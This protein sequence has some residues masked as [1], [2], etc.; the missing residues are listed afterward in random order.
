MSVAE[1]AVWIIEQRRAEPLTLEDV[2]AACGVSR[3]HLTRAFAQAFG[4]P[5]IAY[6]RARRLSEAAKALAG[7]GDDIASIALDA[8]YGSHEA[9]SRAF[10]EAFDMAPSALRA[11]G[12]LTR[13]TLAEPPKMEAYMPEYLPPPRFEERAAFEVAGLTRR[14]GHAETAG[15]P[16]LWA[17]FAPHIGHV[18]GAKGDAA[19][20]LCFAAGDESAFDYMAAVEIAPGAAPG[21]GLETRRV[22]A[23]RYAVFTHSGHV[24]GVR[25]TM[26]AI[27]NHWLPSAEVEYAEGPDF[28]VYGARFDPET[29][30]GDV[31]IWLPVR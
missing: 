1:R 18:D 11:C 4:A 19:Y 15:I 31:E 12:D 13:L 7:T 2:A 6:L 16:S 14:Y 26:F 21:G 27:L 25:N 30:S 24:S 23:A 8:G 28:E 9:F 10:R 3:F 5:A 22:A 29:G 17:E 20:G